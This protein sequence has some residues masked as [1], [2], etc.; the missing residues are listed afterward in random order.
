MSVLAALIVVV[1]VLVAV[2]L[3]VA[4]VRSWSDGRGVGRKPLIVAVAVAAMI[5]VQLPLPEGPSW[6]NVPLAFVIVAGQ[7]N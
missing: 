6:R 7:I 1:S 5:M 4:A 3:G 2:T